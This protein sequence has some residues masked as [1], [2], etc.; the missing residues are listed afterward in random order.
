MEERGEEETR[1]KEGILRAKKMMMRG[2]P[3]NN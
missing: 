3:N 2:T 1:W